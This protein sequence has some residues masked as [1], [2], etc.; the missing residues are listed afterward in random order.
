MKHISLFTLFL[1]ILSIVAFGQ[2]DTVYYFDKYDS[3]CSKDNFKRKV[4]VEYHKRG[5]IE[6][7]NTYTDILGKIKIQNY[8]LKQLSDSIYID[9]DRKVKYN[10]QYNPDSSLYLIKKYKNNI[11]I[12][13]GNSSSMFPQIYQGKVTRYYKLNGNLLSIANYKNNKITDYKW[14]MIDGTRGVDSL[15]FYADSSASFNNTGIVGFSNYVTRNLRYPKEAA[16]QGASGTVT[17][18]FVVMEDGSLTNVQITNDANAYLKHEAVRVILTS[19]NK[20]TPA[21]CN[22]R[23]VRTIYT[24]PVVFVLK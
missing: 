13:T 22:G 20:W 2:T 11:L 23:K 12:E 14:W 18:D 21:Y 19:D 4:M 17:V 16:E 10:I 7:T 6:I 5:K 24:I 8:S 9:K 1:A 3:P 15:C